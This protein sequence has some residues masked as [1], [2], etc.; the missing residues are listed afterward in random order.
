LQSKA[1]TGRG[2]GST[3]GFQPGAGNALCCFHGSTRQHRYLLL[4]DIVYF[5]SSKA[6]ALKVAE[7]SFQHK[8]AS[9]IASSLKRCIAVIVGVTVQLSTAATLIKQVNVEARASLMD[10]LD[11]VEAQLQPV[12][13]KAKKAF[14]KVR[15]QYLL[16]PVLPCIRKIE[17]E[18]PEDNVIWFLWFHLV[19]FRLD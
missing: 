14:G 10:R 13:Q 8:S 15:R 11:I 2:A 3:S 6:G 5:I 1:V 16:V 12:M 4:A 18:C 9:N 17:V 19:H 7:C